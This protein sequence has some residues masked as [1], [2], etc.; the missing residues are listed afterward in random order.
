MLE[1]TLR[2]A[3][4]AVLGVDD[5]G[6]AIECL[7]KESFDLIVTDLELPTRDGFE[8][9][10]GSRENDP[11]APVIVMTAHG[12]VENAVRAMKEGAYD[13]LTK[14]VDTDRLILL[15]QRAL[16]RR[17]LEVRSRVL[18]EG[19]SPPIIAGTSRAME[20]VLRLA[21]KVASS[22]AAVL[23]L[24][25]SGTG[26]EL[27]AR[28]IHFA[29]RRSRN[30][31]VALNCAAIPA[32]LIESELF[33]A[34]KGAYTGADRLRVGKF[35]LADGG[36]LF[37]DE[38]GDL[39]ISLQSKLLRVLEE[40]TVTRVG[41]NRS[42]RV[43]VR[44]ITATNRSLEEAIAAGTFREDLFYRLNVF[45]IHLPPLRKR[46]EDVSI[47][48]RQF[49]GDL[50]AEMRRGDLRL[51]PGAEEKLLSYDWPGNVRELRNILER[52]VILSDG[53]EVSA[54]LISIDQ[55]GATVATSGR[56]DLRSVVRE[57]TKRAE[58]EI[59]ARVLDECSGNKS[60]AARRLNVSYRSL[61]SKVKEY[62]L[63]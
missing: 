31:L 24:G 56:E 10:A 62:D 8:V 2:D 20:R 54:D 45:P 40:K 32:T 50:S 15:A 23:L 25:E 14:P 17:A 43:D 30:Q 18:E 5:G 33:G 7:R 27:F 59:I 49:L 52:A 34:E 41:G 35:E 42:I 29:S 63:R 61:W 44:L 16:E 13:F 47:I 38:I 12:T 51:S 60:E 19:V 11:L 21:D 37:F 39:E 53:D 26:K 6:K 48:A 3:G 46:M 1:E 9:L 57:A 36:T 28:H 55:G 22:D 4:Y 58:V